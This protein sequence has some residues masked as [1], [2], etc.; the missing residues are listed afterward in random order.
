[1]CEKCVQGQ[2]LLTCSFG[3]EKK[4]RTTFAEPTKS[5]KIMRGSKMT[6]MAYFPKKFYINQPLCPCH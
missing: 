5:K 3:I 2:L 1:M 6:T 4:L